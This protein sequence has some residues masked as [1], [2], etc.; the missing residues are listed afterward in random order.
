[1][2]EIRTVAKGMVAELRAFEE[3]WFNFE[4]GFTDDAPAPSLE[5]GEFDF[6][7]IK[8]LL[9][10]LRLG[11]VCTLPRYLKGVSQYKTPV[12]YTIVNLTPDLEHKFD[13][14]KEG[15]TLLVEELCDWKVEIRPCGEEGASVQHSFK[16][17]GRRGGVWLAHKSYSRHGDYIVNLPEESGEYTMDCFRSHVDLFE[18]ER[19]VDRVPVRYPLKKLFPFDKNQVSVLKGDSVLSLPT[20]IMHQNSL[21]W[22]SSNNVEV[23]HHVPREV[24]ETTYYLK[25]WCRDKEQWMQVI[26]D[27][28]NPVTWNIN[29]TDW[30]F[31]AII[32]SIRF[33]PS[34][35]SQGIFLRGEWDTKGTLPSTIQWDMIVGVSVD[36]FSVEFGHQTIDIRCKATDGYST[37]VEFQINGFDDVANRTFEFPPERDFGAEALDCIAITLITRSGNIIAIDY[38]TTKLPEGLTKTI[39]LWVGTN[40]AIEIRPDEHKT[41]R[42]AS[43]L[44]TASIFAKPSWHPYGRDITQVLTMVAEKA[45]QP[46]PYALDTHRRHLAWHPNLLDL[47]NQTPTEDALEHHLVSA[48]TELRLDGIHGASLRPLLFQFHEDGDTTVHKLTPFGSTYETPQP[49]CIFYNENDEDLAILRLNDDELQGIEFNDDFEI[50]PNGGLTFRKSGHYIYAIQPTE[51]IFLD[52][53]KKRTTG[54]HGPIV[55]VD[56]WYFGRR[57]T[58]VVCIE[59]V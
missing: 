26:D 44:Q 39:H 58:T 41:I 53:P 45:T 42:L 6:D 48:N 8:E 31:Q 23:A 25:G 47:S 12:E 19:L 28:E 49:Y 22:F 38:D 43:P 54:D 56:K 29:V 50:G 9:N 40:H 11:R 24:D 14:S 46:S 15:C 36:G 16:P 55:D 51:Y 20:P 35:D 34:V 7:P 59:V 3:Q 32:D 5:I 18:N 37:S 30:D 2:T 4:P 17:T 10:S 33:Q 13:F 21:R 27:N 1:M 57:Y 52:K